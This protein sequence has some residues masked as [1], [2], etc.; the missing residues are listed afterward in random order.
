MAF[1]KIVGAGIHTLSNVHTHNINSSGIITATQFVGLHSGTDGNFS[2][3]VTIDG[4]LTVNGTTTTLDT[5]LTEVD[6]LEVAANNSTVGAAITQSG[7]GDILNLYDGSTEVFSVADGGAVAATGNLT[8]TNTEPSIFFTDTNGNP[9]YKLFTDQGVFKI[10]DTTY[11]ATRLQ[12]NTNG[13]LTIAGNTTFTNGLTL[14]PGTISAVNTIAQRIGDTDTKIRFPGQGQFSFET[15][16]YERFKFTETDATLLNYAANHKVGIGTDVLVA[17]LDVKNNFNGPVLKLNDSHMNKYMT[18]RG[19]GSPN[20]MVIDAYEGG[21]GGAAIDL[22]SNGDTKVRITSTGFLKVNS[23]DSGSYHTIRLNTT[24]N[25]A[26]KD[27]LHVHSSVDGAI[28]ASGYGVRLNFSG[29]QSNGNEY[30]FGGIA[31][32]FNST[33][34]TYGDLAFY[35]NNNGTNGERARITSTGNF[36]I[37]TNSPV[38][39]LHIHNSGTGAADHAY[40]FFTT[41][42]T[43]ST[44]SDGLTVGVAANQVA[45][46]NYREAGTLSL[47]T[48]STPR[49]SISATGTSTFKGAGGGTEQVKIE[50]EGGGAGIFIA[51]YQGVNA[52]DNSSRLGVGKDDNALIFMNASGSQVQNFAI[53]TTDSV[54]LVL[55]THNTKRLQITGDGQ[56]EIGNEFVNA[57]NA[58]ANIS[59]FLSGTRSGAYGGA[60]TNAIIFDNQTA[61]VDAGGSLTLAGYSG[62]S[63]IAKALIRGGNEGSASTNAGYFSVFTRPAS[64]SLSEKLRIDSAGRCIIG[65]GTHAGGSALVVKG[66]NQNTYSTIGMFSNHT[67]PSDDTQLAQIRF[68]SNASA[69]GASIQVHADAD[70][71]NNDYPARMS[72]DLAPN[73]S[74]S[75]QNRLV[76]DGVGMKIFRPGFANNG[77]QGTAMYLEV[78]TDMT[79]VN[80]PTGGS[81]TSGVFRIE[82]RGGNNNR[83]H[84]IEFRNRN[85]GDVRIL[86]RDRGS[87]N[88]AD[89]IFAV[90]DGNTFG[91]GGTI[92]EYMRIKSEGVIEARTASGNYYPIASARDGSTSARYATSAWEIKKTLGPRAK[93]GYYYLKNPYD[94]TVSQWWCDMTTDGGGW[95]L[96]AHTGEGTMSDQ[97]TGGTHWWNRSDKGGF[98]SIGSGYYAGGGFWRTSGGAWAENTCGQL[99]WDVR[100]HQSYYDNYANSKVVFNWGTDQAIPSGNSGYSNIPGASNRNFHAW[101]YEV[102]GAPGFNPSN[103]HQNTR[104]NTI[105]GGNYFTE[106]MVMTW[107]FRGT[108]GGGDDGENGPYWMIGAHAN[109]LHQHYEESLSGDSTGNGKYQVVSNEGTAWS[110]GGDNDGYPRIARISDNGTCNVWLR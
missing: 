6:K 11:S 41:G 62:T 104:N 99:M 68:G 38:A 28:A 45:S 78:G 34:A 19:G 92:R 73:G 106:H 66:G 33:G 96:V 51:N 46:V 25:N 23:S 31:G 12:V 18:I 39:R 35:T 17:K 24:T 98:N 59:F 108:G 61:A 87:S 85:S 36:G 69:V 49:I 81:D 65:G 77:A 75:R 55:S 47:N 107:S 16:G 8:I 52:G 4:N 72:F 76:I 29:E 10:Y 56:V 54:P 71:G 97:G 42:D 74:N 80:T 79:A 14:N 9:D 67:N 102:V 2:G 60:H 88:Y 63:A 7:T 26:I 3:N 20:R 22:A 109:G 82:D 64:G 101:C 110:N 105:N 5:N 21:G 13:T 44:A 53:G 83:Y 15:N 70:W 37:G 57:A 94:N 40:A 86:N 30:T 58:D 50:S 89:L 27:V 91:A 100:T 32:L 43:G 90:D 48:S 93:N 84:G 95:I 103:Y 1:T